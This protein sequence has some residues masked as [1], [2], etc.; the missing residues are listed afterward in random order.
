MLPLDFQYS[1]CGNHVYAFGTT[2]SR[3]LCADLATGQVAW[4]QKIDQNAQYTS[5]IVADG[6]VIALAP[7]WLYLVQASPDGWQLLGKAKVGAEVW[8]SPALADGKVLV[9]TGKNVVCYD[10]SRP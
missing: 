4:D 1:R 10:L 8:T 6:K 2:Q 3:A 9:R 5:P 7:P